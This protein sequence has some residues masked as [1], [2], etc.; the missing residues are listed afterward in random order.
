MIRRAS[1]RFIITL[2]V[3]ASLFMLSGQAAG[4]SIRDLI[5]GDGKSARGTWRYKMTVEIETPEGIKTGSAV[6]EVSA[7]SLTYSLSGAG[8]R[9][10]IEKGEAVVVDLGKRGTV[11]ALMRG[12]GG[13]VD[14]RY[15]IVF[16]AFP[17]ERGGLTPEGIQHYREMKSS[18][19][20]VLPVDLYPMFVRFR[21]MNDPKTVENLLETEAVGQGWPKKNKLKADHF[22]EAF[23]E[24]VRIKSVTMEMTEEEVNWQGIE[25]WLPWLSEYYG[26]TLDGQRYHTIKS[27]F[28]FANS[29]GTGSFSTGGYNGQ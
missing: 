22:E 29:L 16:K 3:I 7:Y 25:K 20:V 10:K 15:S 9:A 21:D 4:D 12:I 11:F 28:P 8:G 27:Q 1:G 13:D 23:G 18:D 17:H 5:A 2:S 19:K 26:K 6:R 14:Y 24:G